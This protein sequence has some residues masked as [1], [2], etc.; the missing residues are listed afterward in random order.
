MADEVYEYVETG[1]ERQV[2]E[3]GKSL[4]LNWSMY[5]LTF[6]YFDGDGS[7]DI[8]VH[9]TGKDEAIAVA[10]DFLEAEG[11]DFKLID[12]DKIVVREVFYRF[13]IS[14]TS[15]IEAPNQIIKK[16]MSKIEEESKIK[17]AQ[18]RDERRI[19]KI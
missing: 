16:V 13:H 8:L 14:Q 19:R 1:L 4:G 18:R 3:T 10:Y 6:P 11:D 2:M 15:V 7:F 5:A 12:P 9:A 17:S